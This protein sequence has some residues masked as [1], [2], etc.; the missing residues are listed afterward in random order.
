MPYPKE[1]Q[2]AINHAKYSA[3]APDKYKCP[4]CPLSS[5]AYYKKLAL[6]TAQRHNTTAR[7]LKTLLGLD[8]KKGIISPERKQILRAHV[9]DNYDKVVAINLLKKGAPSRFTPHHTI[10]YKR[11]PQTLERLKKHIKNITKHK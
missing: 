6:H 3:Y 7:E 10:N 11:S 4:L 1:K 5:P 9:S 8:T 2:D